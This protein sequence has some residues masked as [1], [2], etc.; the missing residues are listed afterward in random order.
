MVSESYDVDYHMTSELLSL[1]R[2]WLKLR[3]KTKNIQLSFI[4]FFQ[5]VDD[6]RL[7]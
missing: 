7:I 6:I 2:S 4:Y 1:L 5:E 3:W